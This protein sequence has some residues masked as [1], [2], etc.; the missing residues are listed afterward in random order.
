MMTYERLHTIVQS[1]TTK[2]PT[3]I[4][5]VHQFRE[6]NS[7]RFVRIR[8]DSR[9]KLIGPK[10]YDCGV[11]SEKDHEFRE[12]FDNPYI[13]R[14]TNEAKLSSAINSEF[15]EN[16]FLAY[17]LWLRCRKADKWLGN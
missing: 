17:G 11:S 2:K 16:Y 8:L 15:F 5:L 7:F 6:K 14:K 12:D 1:A 13:L 4:Y 9:A 3:F 10:L